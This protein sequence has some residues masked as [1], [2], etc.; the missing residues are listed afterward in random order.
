MSFYYEGQGT[1]PSLNQAY[2]VTVTNQRSVRWWHFVLFGIS[3]V[4]ASVG[5]FAHVVLG[6]LQQVDA[7]VPAVLNSAQ[8]TP[9]APATLALKVP[10]NSVLSPESKQLQRSIESW[11]KANSGATWSVQVSQVDGELAA[12]YRAD[13]SYRIASLYKLFL[14]QPLAS[15]VPSSNWDGKINEKTYKECVD[16]MLRLSDNPCA[17]AIGSRLGWS[18]VDKH[19]RSLGYGNTHLSVGDATGT[20]GDTTKLLQ[21]L[22]SEN[23]FDSLASTLELAAMG[24]PKKGEGIRSGCK[25]CK[26][27]NKTGDIDGFKHDAALIEKNGHVYSVVILS[28]DGSWKQISDLTAIIQEYL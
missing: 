11:V 23:G 8:Q 10:Q 15:K 17:E 21:N 12:S 27:Y 20:A 19:L 25:D 24:V 3:L 26:V 5:V 2:V 6:N 28:Q 22:Y 18:Y 9:E 16:A 1:Y 13:Q 7:Q 4:M 14:L